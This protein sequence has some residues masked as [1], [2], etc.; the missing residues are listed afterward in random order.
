[1]CTKGSCFLIFRRSDVYLSLLIA[2]KHT[3]CMFPLTPCPELQSFCQSALLLT[4]L[5][6]KAWWYAELRREENAPEIS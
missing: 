3:E 4:G 2:F 6:S 5:Q 1:M